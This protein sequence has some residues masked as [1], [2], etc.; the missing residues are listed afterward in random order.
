VGGLNSIEMEA[1]I[2]QSMKVD[3]C[4]R[5]IV[6]NDESAILLVCPFIAVKLDR[7]T[8]EKSEPADETIVSTFQ[9]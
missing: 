9:T 8:G 3:V 4:V 1:M 2:S 5:F 6:K 7:H